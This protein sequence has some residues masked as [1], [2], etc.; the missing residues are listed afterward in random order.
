M[1]LQPVQSIERQQPD[2]ALAY[3]QLAP[4]VTEAHA[5]YD[6]G[7]LDKCEAVLRQARGLILLG[8]LGFQQPDPDQ[9]LGPEVI[10][11]DIVDI[12]R[13]DFRPPPAL[14]RRRFD[15]DGPGGRVRPC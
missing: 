3:A 12:Q 7:R 1:S 11:A 2:L 4:L 5:Y 15:A 14:R 13:G 8:G 6:S 10:K 9:T